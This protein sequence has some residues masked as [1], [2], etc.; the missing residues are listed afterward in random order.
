M[1]TKANRKQAEPP[2]WAYLLSF[3]AALFALFEIYDSAIRGPFV[4]DDLYLPYANSHAASIPFQLWMGVRPVLGLSFWA[5]FQLW[6][7]NTLP[8]HVTNLLLHFTSSVILFFIFRKLLA[9]GF[10]AEPVRTLL[11]AFGSALFL[12]HP[13]QTEVVA[14]IASRSEALSVFFFLA[15]FCT[16]LYRRTLAINWPATGLVLLFFVLAVG[17]KEHTLTLP[18]LLLLTDYFWNPGFSFSG[19]R[20]NARLYLPILTAGVLGVMFIFRYVASDPMI[21]FHIEGLGPG[22]YF[23]TESRAI[24]KYLQLFVFPASQ[25]VDYDFPLSHT[26]TEHGAL[27]AVA[28]LLL[29]SMAAILVRK[30]YPFAAYGFLTFLLL[31]SPTSLF[32]PIND[33]L[34]ERRLYLP[35]FALVLILFEPLRRVRVRPFPLGVALAVICAVA[36]YA[37]SQR[38][39]VW[40]SVTD[41][42]RDAAE[43]SPGKARVHI[44]YAN[45]LYHQGRC[46][47]AVEE[48]GTASRLKTTDYILY[49]NLAAAYDCI[50]ASADAMEMLNRSLAIKPQASTYALLGR[51]L[52]KEGKLDQS[53]SALQAAIG[54]DSQFAP[55][56]A[57]R[58]AAYAALGKP[59]PAYDD[60]QTC[61]RLDP[62][63]QVAQQ[64]LA[65]L[66]QRR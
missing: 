33:V 18:A 32:I 4:F 49:F 41:L 9:F 44:G 15:A 17:S 39:H 50:H 64:G 59:Q 61:L 47:E 57:Y 23:L 56:Y 60:Y 31:L 52:G 7:Q 38:A 30:I 40:G 65:Q 2:L 14:Y 35:F 22:T 43:K 8:Y 51:I 42:F 54:L 1:A 20:A 3:V 34:V 58:G 21:G 5:D 13:I 55:A 6:G 62:Q 37:T 11:S 26:L 29:L 45:A 48:Y 28:G 36:A 63:N 10:T 46:R 16:F 25:N 12:V 19:I 53:L 66:T 24:F 27:L